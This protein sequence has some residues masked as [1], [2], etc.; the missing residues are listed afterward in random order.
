MK[1]HPLV[2]FIDS[3]PKLP[4]KR[5]AFNGHTRST[6]QT[7]IK[8]WTEEPLPEKGKAVIVCHP[9]QQM[10]RITLP[11]PALYS[12]NGGRLFAFET[13]SNV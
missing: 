13:W 2:S 6:A 5:L 3:L 4:G 9:N 10:I 12:P 7:L 8:N 1:I 11:V